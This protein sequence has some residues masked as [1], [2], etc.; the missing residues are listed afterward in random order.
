MRS[1][2]WL[3]LAV[4]G[5]LIPDAGAAN[6]EDGAKAVRSFLMTWLIDQV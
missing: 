6:R 2:R 4:V 1:T 3:C 5:L